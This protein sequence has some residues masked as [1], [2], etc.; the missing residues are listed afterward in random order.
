[1]INLFDMLVVAATLGFAYRGWIAGLE[2]ASIEALELLAC[3]SIAVLTHEAV[4]AFLH[5]GVTLVLGDGVSVSWSILLAFCLLGW[6]TFACIR[7]LVHGKP[8]DDD[9]QDGDVD[10]LGDRVAGAIAGGFGGVLFVGGALVTIS[11][12]P[13]LAGIKPSGDRMLL[14]VGKTVLRAGGQFAM[15]HHE[16]RS[17]PLWGEPPS[18]VSDLKARLTS[19]PRFD[20]DDNGDYSEAD[21]FRDVDGNGTFSKDLYYKDVDGDGVRRIGLID[22][23]VVG[24]WD[25][26]LISDDRARPDS[27]P[28]MT[29]EPTAPK[30]EVTQPPKPGEQAP[31]KQARPPTPDG[32][33]KRPAAKIKDGKKAAGGKDG[34]KAAGGKDGEKETGEKQP[35]DDF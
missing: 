31:A 2:S 15:E 18:R 4:A 14:D 1:M 34:K 12:V 3:L 35:E 30:P 7:L 10:P 28:A 26:E 20:T 5:D 29:K 6:G 21:R 24:R 13:F 17:L 11:M 16:G 32:T 23:Y 8:A 25:G 22:K 19:E 27:K 9:D 33:T